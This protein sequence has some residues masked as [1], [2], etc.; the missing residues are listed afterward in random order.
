MDKS[1][2]NKSDAFHLA[3]TPSSRKMTYDRKEGAGAGQNPTA[4]GGA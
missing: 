2:N 3:L 1:L 4:A